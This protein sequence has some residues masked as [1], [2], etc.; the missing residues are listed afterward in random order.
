MQRL[1][2]VVEVGCGERSRLAESVL[3][4]RRLRRGSLTCRCAGRLES[5]G[6]ESG[7]QDGWLRC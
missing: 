4:D 6:V 2:Q 5:L 7:S 3:E 1:A